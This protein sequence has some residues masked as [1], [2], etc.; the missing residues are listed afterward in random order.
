[1]RYWL[2]RFALYILRRYGYMER[3]T[4]CVLRDML[5]EERNAL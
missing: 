5:E 2:V 3:L 4:W 1:M